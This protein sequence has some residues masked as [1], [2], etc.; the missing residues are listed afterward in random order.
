MKFTDGGG[1]EVCSKFVFQVNWGF[2]FMFALK[3]TN[4]NW[5]EVAMNNS[6]M[7]EI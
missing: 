5:L 2:T 4:K 1:V 6:K 7:K 3:N